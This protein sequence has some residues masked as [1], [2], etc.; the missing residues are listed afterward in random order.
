MVQ[1][2]QF[3]INY[4]IINTFV[5]ALNT[6]N[7]TNIRIRYF[8]IFSI[9]ISFVLFILELLLGSVSFSPTQII[10][11]L[12]TGNFDDKILE[13]IIFDFRLPKAITVLLAGSALSVSG[14]LMQTVFRNALAGPYILGIS[15]GASLGV[16][17]VVLSAGAYGFGFWLSQIGIVIAAMI[18]AMAVLLLILSVSVRVKDIMTILILGI[19]FG[20][21]TSAITSILQYFSNE[22]ALKMYVVWTMG[23]VSGVSGSRLILFAVIVVIGHLLAL[24]V[25][26]PLNVLNIGENYAKSLGFN[27]LNIR[28][29]VFLATSLLAGAT[30][31]FCGPIGFIGI[32]VP[33][34]VRFI[35]NTSNHKVT[36]PA[37]IIMGINVLLLCDIIAQLPGSNIVLPI[38]AVASLMGIPVVIY[39]IFGSHHKK[40]NI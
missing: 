1:I 35:L 8:F 2:A 25:S 34:V 10:K 9:I 30:T 21:A 7:K 29:L 28:L 36:I 38:N 37:T 23:S 16:A 14:L 5:K 3:L 15:S 27:V 6:N 32:A 33:H 11:S 13:S 20:A 17:I 40:V 4:F 39:V 26:R 18:G 12:F 31:A 19:M 22:S 24:I